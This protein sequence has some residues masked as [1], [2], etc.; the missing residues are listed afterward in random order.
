M[1]SYFYG[2]T[3]ISDGAGQAAIMFGT[4]LFAGGIWFFVRYLA[5]YRAAYDSVSRTM[6]YPPTVVS[7]VIVLIGFVLTSWGFNHMFNWFDSQKYDTSIFHD[8]LYGDYLN[9]TIFGFE[10]PYSMPEYEVAFDTGGIISYGLLAL[11]AFSCYITYLLF[12]YI[13]RRKTD[14]VSSQDI[15]VAILYGPVLAA[16]SLLM[17]YVWLNFVCGEIF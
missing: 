8:L 10:L 11:L 9:A 2:H 6:F 7:A 16:A 12:S 13:G 5:S 1:D 3:A 14:P 4:L 15:I 17:E